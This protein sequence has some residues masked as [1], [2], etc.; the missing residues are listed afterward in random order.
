MQLKR[1]QQRVWAQVGNGL[2][3]T[4]MLHL[5]MRKSKVNNLCLLHCPLNVY[6]EINFGHASIFF[7]F[8][9]KVHNTTNEKKA[10]KLNRP[11]AMKRRIAYVSAF[12]IGLYSIYSAFFS[13][14][15]GYL[16][17][18]FSCIPVLFV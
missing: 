6:W 8:F 14:S 5:M 2:N 13:Q 1:M 9:F 10:K 11:R 12:R 4:R 16:L 7:Y 15:V 17:L 18:A 3:S